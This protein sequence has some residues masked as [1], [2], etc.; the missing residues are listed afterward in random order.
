VSGHQVEA[1]KILAELE[2][3]AK[4]Q[5]VSSYL[6]AT[7]YAGLGD[8]RRALDLLEQAFTQDSLDIVQLK[9]DP[10]LDSLR[11]EPRFQALMKKI[12]FPE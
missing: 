2:D 5:F 10:E 12:N 9:V 6:L 1:R 7:V 8:K 11:D 4:Q 3:R